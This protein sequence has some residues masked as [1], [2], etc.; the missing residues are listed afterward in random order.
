M[1]LDWAEK[2]R[3]KRLADIV[4]NV[5]SI[6]ALA[7]WAEN[8]GT[9]TMKKRAALLVGR[10]GIGKTTAAHALAL[11]RGWSIIEL[12]ASDQRNTAAI[13][14]VATR[15]S[16]YETFTRDGEFKSAALGE[17]KLI[18][19]DEADNVAGRQDQGGYRA[20][21]ELIRETKQP[22]I[23]VANDYYELRR[24]ASSLDSLC[25]VLKFD[26][27]RQPSIVRRLGEICALEKVA[28]PK[29][30]LD[31]IADR[32]GGDMR[33]AV[34]DL[35]T[36]LNGNPGEVGEN[37]LAAIGARDV[38]LS[39]FDAVRKVF[40]AKDFKR[41]RQAT[42]DIDEEPSD[43][44]TWMEHNVAIA[45]E[46]PADLDSAYHALARADVFISRAERMKYYGFWSYGTDM[47]TAGVAQSRR[48]PLRVGFRYEFPFWI[49]MMGS[50]KGKRAVRRSLSLKLAFYTHSS[51]GE[52]LSESMP[53]YAGIFGGKESAELRRNLL[54]SLSLSEEEI[55]YL[56]DVKIDSD[57]VAR[58]LE[59]GRR[60]AALDDKPDK[61]LANAGP[62]AVPKP[63]R[64]AQRSLGEF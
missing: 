60:L 54:T 45:F 13:K 40:S 4:G 25:L 50:S 1:G 29:A 21:I 32:S 59:E 2:Y 52:V 64:R 61:T 3:P 35:Q 43:F 38:Q 10:P 5:A 12:N 46:S 58:V 26:A 7:D 56:L 27:P 62:G 57:E 37:A 41:A 53:L 16:V 9:P 17:R 24:K 47:M 63:E 39:P 6:K 20:I 28:A 48:A 51:S 11:E 19:L 49:R 42:M 33:S 8:W 18:I 30:V 14:D 34:N 31:S 22:V 44:L 55:A 15:G 23:L 36:V